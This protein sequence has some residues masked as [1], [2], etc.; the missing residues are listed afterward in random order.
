MNFLHCQSPLSDGFCPLAWDNREPL[1]LS[2][3]LWI[4]NQIT[5]DLTK[6]P[7]YLGGAIGFALWRTETTSTCGSS[8]FSVREHNA[9]DAA[10]RP[11]VGALVYESRVE[12]GAIYLAFED[13]VMQTSD[14][15]NGGKTD[16]DYNDY[17]AYVSGCFG[18]IPGGPG[19]AGGG[20]GEAGAPS[21]AGAGMNGG[22]GGA[23]VTGGTAG[24]RQ[25]ADGGEASFTPEPGHM[26]GGSGGDGTQGFPTNS[27]SSGSGSSAAES[28]DDGGCGCRLGPRD[29]LNVSSLLV[30]GASV[31][32]LR[33]RRRRCGR[34][35][36]K[37]S[38]VT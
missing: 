36:W 31:G 17:V 11:Y 13:G 10:D 2:K 23:A 9:R 32:W 22:P 18:Q 8:R 26:D 24:A 35:P 5:V 3:K 34:P 37:G 28:H 6:D 25:A 16:G 15:T 4:P 27:G 1:D 29:E 14:W 7:R 33:I 12:P 38:G 19:G 21:A 20:A 30:V